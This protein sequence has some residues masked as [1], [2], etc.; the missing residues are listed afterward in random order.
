MKLAEAL[1]ARKT[2]EARLARLEERLDA[3]ARVEAGL[4]PPES[5]DALYA[6]VEKTAAAISGM[7]SRI[8]RTNV[9]TVVEGRILADWIAERDVAQRRFRVLQNVLR[10]AAPSFDRYGGPGAVR[11]TAT[12][13]VARRHAE[14][15]ALELRV[16]ALDARIQQANWETELL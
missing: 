10:A 6:E 16:N 13:D 9:E 5:P 11:S 4:E 15:D 12:F 2:L 14:L 8:A 1:N 3:S 7:L